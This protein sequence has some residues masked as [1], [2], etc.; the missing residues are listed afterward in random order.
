MPRNL[1][2]DEIQES[3]YQ[4]EDEQN[5]TFIL[6]IDNPLEVKVATYVRKCIYLRRSKGNAIQWEKADGIMVLYGMPFYKLLPYQTFEEYSTAINV[7]SF[8]PQNSRYLVMQFASPQSCAEFLNRYE[9]GYKAFGYDFDLLKSLF[10]DDATA[11]WINE[12]DLFKLRTMFIKYWTKFDKINGVKFLSLFYPFDSPVRQQND[13]ILEIEGELQFTSE[14]VFWAASQFEDAMLPVI[15]ELPWSAMCFS[16]GIDDQD[17]RNYVNMWLGL[18][19]SPESFIGKAYFDIDDQHRS[20][21][22]KYGYAF[23]P[24]VGEETIFHFAEPVSFIQLDLWIY[25]ISLIDVRDLPLNAFRYDYHIAYSQFPQTNLSHVP[26]FDRLLA[27]FVDWPTAKYEDMGKVF[28]E[29]MMFAFCKGYLREI[30]HQ[31]D[32]ASEVLL[33]PSATWDWRMEDEEE[34]VQYGHEHLHKAYE[35]QVINWQMSRLDRAKIIGDRYAFSW[36]MEDRSVWMF[37]FPIYM[38]DVYKIHEL[39]DDSVAFAKDNHFQLLRFP[40]QNEID[41][42]LNQVSMG[43]ISLSGEYEPKIA[44]R[45]NAIRQ[46]VYKMGYSHYNELISQLFR[47]ILISAED[48]METYINLFIP[49]LCKNQTTVLEIVYES[50]QEPAEINSPVV[51]NITWPS[52][53]F[54]D[55]LK[56]TVADAVAAYEDATERKKFYDL[57]ERKYTAIR[58][59]LYLAGFPSDMTDQAGFRHNGEWALSYAKIAPNMFVI[60]EFKKFSPY[61]LMPLVSKERIMNAEIFLRGLDL[62]RRDNIS[63][64]VKEY[65]LIYSSFV[66]SRGF[67]QSHLDIEEYVQKESIHMADVT[68]QEQIDAQTRRTNFISPA[69]KN[70]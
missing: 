3:L 23:K 51:T 58:K 35:N 67:M 64:M 15:T 50:P 45:S 63:L 70:T 25:V 30:Y 43:S 22:S 28:N 65:H 6:S 41:F 42:L 27:A 59:I 69:S 16:G 44:M 17:H 2:L 60:P 36:R 20:R 7:Y 19:S 40:G 39:N 37:D 38:V 33:E 26:Y 34:N 54:A 5:A 32:L 21:L 46:I 61:D 18:R 13:E 66:M 4:Q 12:F 55:I 24:Y 11:T 62:V 49:Q 47:Q 53:C 9:Q 1:N 29:T 31:R 56:E 8:V 48:P 57:M 14:D 52:M 10:Y 68:L